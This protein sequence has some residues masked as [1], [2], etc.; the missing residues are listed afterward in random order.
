MS[1]WHIDESHSEI[2]FKVKHLMVSNVKGMFGKFSGTLTTDDDA[3]TNAKVSFEA[4]DT[5]TGF[6]HL[7]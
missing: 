1:T 2:G 6:H 5:S 7:V 3:L 4:D